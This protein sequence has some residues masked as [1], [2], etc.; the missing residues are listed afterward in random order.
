MVVAAATVVLLAA[1]GAR[2]GLL[3]DGA[4][5]LSSTATAGTTTT[6]GAGA[7]GGVAA[8]KPG[9]APVVLATGQF[10]PGGL[11]I[12]ADFVYFTTG[13]EGCQTLP[14]V[15][16]VSKQGGNVEV[17]AKT[18]RPSHAI[19][20]DGENVYWSDDPTSVCST[21]QDKGFAI[22]AAPKGGGGPTATLALADDI[23]AP[24]DIAVDD[25]HVYW[26]DPVAAIILRVPKGGGMP[27][28]VSG[29]PQATAIALFGDRVYWTS[30]VVVVSAPKD[31]G[32]NTFSLLSIFPGGTTL[33]GIA[34]DANGVYFGGASPCQGADCSIMGF[35]QRTE[36]D[37]GSQATI[38]GGPDEQP[39]RVAVDG[40][41]VYWTQWNQSNP[42]VLAGTVMRADAA[43]GNV[44]TIA[45][46]KAPFGIAV[47]GACVYWTDSGD[48]R[49]WR[50]PK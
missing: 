4:G 41:H 10:S 25:T 30:L 27:Q 34:V 46:G 40:S 5:G 47:D 37:G 26:G 48:G 50:A 7:G 16:R 11:V 17:L 21:P 39:E 44:V 45:S 36:L 31:N 35:V 6:A 12:D 9:D 15:S 43:G 13:H 22:L 8:C 29:G 42:M 38:A 3:V 14:G 23:E 20:V 24:A 33:G 32:P 19:G 18:M 28:I 2:G 49:V 1:C